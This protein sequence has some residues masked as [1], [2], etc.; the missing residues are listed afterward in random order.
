MNS[1]VDLR[2]SFFK[3]KVTTLMTKPNVIKIFNNPMSK[4]KNPQVI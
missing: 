2:Q 1:F 4:K 3:N